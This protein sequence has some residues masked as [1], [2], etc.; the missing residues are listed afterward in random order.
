MRLLPRLTIVV[1]LVVFLSHSAL[2]HSQSRRP[3][4]SLLTIDDPVIHTPSH[5]VHALS[6]FDIV[7]RIHSSERRTR[8]SLEPN[9][10]I[11]PEGAGVT[12]LN[13]KGEAQRWEP[14]DRS[15]HRVFKGGVWA[16]N[17][18]GSWSNVG[19]ARINVVTDG[20]SPLFEGAFSIVHDN[21]H[22]QLRS[23][24]LET[25]HEHDPLMGLSFENDMVLWRDSD[26]IRRGGHQGLKRRERELAC[27]AD[28]LH[29]NSN[30]NHP[31]YWGMVKRD[32]S[33]S[34]WGS[35]SLS[36]L[37]AKRQIDTSGMPTGG[38]SGGANLIST[39][40]QTAGCPSTRKVALIGVATDCTYTATF[41]SNE[42]ARSHVIQTINTASEVYEKTFNITLGL[43]NLTVSNAT[44]PGSPPSTA[45]WNIGCDG[46]TTI[47]DRLNTFSQWRGQFQDDNAYWM[48]LTNC[49]TGAEVGLSWLGELCVNKVT[50][51]NNESTSGANVVAKT[52]TEWQVI[53]HESGHMFGAVHDCDSQTC[54]D[55]TTVQAQQC[56]PLSSTTCDAGGQFI[57]NPSTGSNINS[58]SAC[59]IGNICSAMKL[60]SVQSSCLSDNKGVTTITGQQC[61]NGIVEEGEDCDCGGPGGCEGDSCCN[62]TTCRFINNAVCDDA[63]EDC[64][65]NCQFSTNG[66]GVCQGSSVGNEISSWVNQHQ[67]LVIGLSSGIGGLLVLSILFCII[68][69]CRKPKRPAGKAG[70]TPMHHQQWPSHT[71]GWNAPPPQSHG[72]YAG[73]SVRYA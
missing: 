71:G 47:T 50:T 69:S 62:P 55:G 35:T 14:I 11:I 49:N 24:Y 37:F 43:Q 52:S 68:R 60:N 67:A 32:L 28:Q 59:T 46:E 39:I 1:C 6:R 48:L 7:F 44:C 54:S 15:Q 18:D 23:K 13:D 57:M 20:P 26:T 53:A 56:C 61:G 8:L 38:N 10:D 21:H 40:G 31:V 30:P 4:R 16:E 58:F 73:Q 66:T 12:Y 72:S 33:R 64:C 41:N 9:Y 70:A 51:G 2:A 22:V 5:R 65:H 3:L 45:P 19:W 25:M 17:G 34:R 36:S 63:N 42:D 27:S 29:F